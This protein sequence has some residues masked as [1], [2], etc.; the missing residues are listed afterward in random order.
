MTDHKPVNKNSDCVVA[1]RFQNSWKEFVEGMPPGSRRVS[2]TLQFILM[3]ASADNR[4]Y[5]RR[6]P[7]NI[8]VS[9]IPRTSTIC[10]KCVVEFLLRQLDLQG[11]AA[12]RSGRSAHGP[13]LVAPEGPH[14]V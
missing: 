12:L 6:A 7:P 8:H 1:L 2:D 3:E 10:G 14:I 13:V 4:V 9:V 11:F 5:N